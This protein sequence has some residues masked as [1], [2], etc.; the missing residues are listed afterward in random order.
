MAIKRFD[1]TWSLYEINL[2]TDRE[3]LNAKSPDIQL[4]KSNLRNKSD[5]PSRSVG[6]GGVQANNG[7]F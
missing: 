1:L 5:L 4:Q 2:V 7:F 3:D 6:S